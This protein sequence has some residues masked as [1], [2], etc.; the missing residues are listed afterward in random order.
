MNYPLKPA[1]VPETLG[2]V[3]PNFRKEAFKVFLSIILFLFTYV[4]LMTAAIG[5]AILL[6]YLGVMMVSAVPR[7]ITLMLGLAMVLAGLMVLYF[8]IKFIFSSKKADR[9]GMVEIKRSEEPDLFAFIEKVNE[10][11]DSPKPK[12]IYLSNQV[13]ASVFYDSSFWSMFFPVKKNLNIGLGVVAAVNLTEF[14]AI[15]A[16]EFGHFSQKSMKLGSYI[17]NVNQV[18][19]NMLF[20]ND[21]FERNLDSMGKDG[22]YFA[23][24]SAITYAV[25][26]LIQKILQKVYTL[27]NKSYMSLSRQME[28]HADAI[29]AKVTGSNHMGPALQRVQI[30]S[31]CYNFLIEKYNGWLAQGY[32]PENIYDN[33]AL[34][35][36][37]FAEENKFE[38]K[39]SF[40]QANEQSFKKLD[41]S[42]VSVEDQW[43]SH[44]SYEDRV[45][46]LEAYNIPTK[47]VED[48]VW[49]LFKNPEETQK[50]FTELMY[51]GVEFGPEVSVQNLTQ[52][53]FEQKLEADHKEYSFPEAY[54]GFYDN[55]FPLDIGLDKSPVKESLK[56]FEEIYHKDRILAL[57]DNSYLH[58]DK[59]TLVQ[60][61]NKEIKVK[62][63]DYDGQKYKRKEV[64]K[65][66]AIIDGEID[67]QTAETARID[68][69]S[70]QYFSSQ[71]QKKA[72]RDNYQQN[73]KDVQEQ[74]GRASQNISLYAK[75]MEIIHPIF[76]GVLDL[77]EARQIDQKLK[78]EEL[79][80]KKAVREY[81]EYEK[82]S[83][84]L[85]EEELDWF[86]KYE[87]SSLNYFA[88]EAFNEDQFN[89]LINTLNKFVEV[90]QVVSFKMKK[91]FLAYQLS[92]K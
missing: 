39:D 81:L 50:K 85:S 47:A 51:A 19:Y 64:N 49:T 68:R 73:Y 61:K 60:I 92:L 70:Y 53:D 18:I 25:V 13:N 30:A 15:L 33:F 76:I 77:D 21:G 88:Y 10:E 59:Q 35:Q 12:R 80:L 62:S 75:F 87:K 40:I 66:I 82:L 22:G 38:I 16:H 44:P 74:L 20:E 83:K 37:N 78:Y 55:Y 72:E 3:N 57:M 42:K 6:G 65:I 17:Y 89:F 69:E 79:R 23:I 71:A 2:E 27:V 48:S 84:H 28:F 46:H 5:L 43:A 52:A 14:K 86:S 58:Q 1:Q 7:F 41:Y 56:S 32:K 24:T 67:K 63:F 9:S 91:E 8:L 90:N 26:G 45:S 34:V 4:I 31:I 11:T 29:S 36:R 54:H